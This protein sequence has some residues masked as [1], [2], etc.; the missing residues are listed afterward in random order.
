LYYGAS[1]NS[2]EIGHITVSRDN[3]WCTCGNHCCLEAVAPTRRWPSKR[4]AS[5]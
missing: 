2:G 5:F 1:G 4:K 3:V